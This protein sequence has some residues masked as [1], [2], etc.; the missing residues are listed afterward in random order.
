MLHV[1]ARPGIVSLLVPNHCPTPEE[2]K[3]DQPPPPLV[4]R[5]F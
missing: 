5:H 4:G 3:S 1:E 2:K